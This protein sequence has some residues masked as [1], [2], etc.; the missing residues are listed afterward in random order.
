M[1]TQSNT[2]RFWRTAC[3]VLCAP[4][5][6]ETALLLSEHR[7]HVSEEAVLVR[8]DTTYVCDTVVIE[9]PVAVR[10]AAA[11]DSILVP[12]LDTVKILDTIY[13]SLPLEQKIYSGEDYR[14][15]VSGYRP[16][17][18]SLQIFRTSI[19]VTNQVERAAA[20]NSHWTFGVQAGYGIVATGGKVGPGPYVG[21]GVTY[22]FGRQRV[23]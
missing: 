17:L 23:K 1:T 2:N 16:S 4:L 11:V 14:A 6:L 9:Q 22:R 7:R 19:E 15:W 20:K 13:V 21:L 3:I 12:V 8:T 10:T 5:L 18:D